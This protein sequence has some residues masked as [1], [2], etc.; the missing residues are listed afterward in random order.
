LQ[1]IQ[2]IKL[3]A[4]QELSTKFALKVKNHWLEIY[5]RIFL[6]GLTNNLSLKII[7]LSCLILT[8]TVIPIIKYCELLNNFAI[9]I[10][11]WD[12]FDSTLNFLLDFQS[13][14]D[15][16]TKVSLILSQHNEHR[17]ILNRLISLVQYWL[18]G[19]VNFRWQVIFGNVAL[20]IWFLVAY[21][22]LRR[23]TD[24]SKTE[25]N[26]L[27]PSF[28]LLP[29][30]PFLLQ[31]QYGDGMLWSSTVIGSFWSIALAILVLHL[32][33]VKF[34]HACLLMPLAVFTQGNGVVLP[35]CGACS[36]AL[37]KRWREL[38]WWI[39][40]T[41][42]ALGLYFNGYK[43]P[44]G[45]PSPI[46]ALMHL[47]RTSSYFLAF[48]G[49]G[50][51]FSNLLLSQIYGSLVLIIFIY[52]FIFRAD[53]RAP[54]LFFTVV[55]LLGTAGVNSLSRAEFGS[56]YA[57]HQDRYRFISCA[58]TATTYLLIISLQ[59]A[60]LRKVTT[61]VV[62][63][64]SIAFCWKSYD[65]YSWRL[66][67]FHTDYLVSDLF[68]WC[69]GGSKLTYPW[70]DRSEPIIN[71]SL[72]SGIY[73]IPE[74]SLSVQAAKHEINIS[75]VKPPKLATAIDRVFTTPKYF[76][77]S[78]W[79]YKSKLRPD[80]STILIAIQSPS[81]AYQ[82]EDVQ[83][84][85][86]IFKPMRVIRPDVKEHFKRTYHDKT[87]FV[88]VI[89]RHLVLADSVMRVIV[90]D[91]KNSVASTLTVKLNSS[92]PDINRPSNLRCFIES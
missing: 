19:S 75:L 66:R 69:F 86:Q 30:Y 53:K 5:R 16:Q 74:S 89:P 28:L 58:L 14:P 73:T 48:I 61:L 70:S 18:Y 84:V 88:A 47:E 56:S 26:F 43:S 9:N 20:I 21:R 3:F 79:A 31:P 10:P 51:G 77:V 12:D 59:S 41:I 91:S 4:F 55:F 50:L 80:K 27:L 63:P 60:K 42:F 37:S 11:A 49:S 29:T 25:N 1:N 83:T 34:W 57:I 76:I 13:A 46:N 15:V 90:A 72:Q 71:R 85:N 33:K 7:L 6:R 2:A 24:S 36:L 81:Q 38:G 68:E 45:H 65:T 62:L 78:G 8:G 87:G 23:V 82:K 92:E 52:C 44:V 64:L 35:I 39:L 40:I 54:E 32:L 22:V 67:L 17:I